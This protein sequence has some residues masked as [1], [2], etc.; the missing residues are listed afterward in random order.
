MHACIQVRKNP[1]MKVVLQI[2]VV[3]K[4]ESFTEEALKGEDIATGP[5][6]TFEF[7]CVTMSR[8]ISS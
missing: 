3:S 2:H 1:F 8:F 6:A 4:K 5:Y 7:T